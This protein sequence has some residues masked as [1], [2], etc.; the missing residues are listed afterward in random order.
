MRDVKN[1]IPFV[2][3]GASLLISASAVAQEKTGTKT[4]F[5]LQPGTAQIIL[6]RPDIS[7]GEQSTGGMFE[8]NADWTAQARKNIER[9]LAAVHSDLGNEIIHYEESL[10]AN[11][12]LVDQYSKLFGVIAG[13][14]LKYQFFE[15][16]R[17]PTKKR[18]ID[19]FDWGVGPGLANIRSLTGADY[20]LYVYTHDEY[21]SVGRKALQI[22]GMVAG[23]PIKSGVHI[24][25]AG[26]IDLKTGQLVW[27]NADGAMGGDVRTEEGAQKRAKQLLEGFPGRP[28]A[29]GKMADAS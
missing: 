8:P 24:G 3:V 18:E 22:G 5:T 14:V 23:F 7:V 19:D 10:G 27:L 21:G 29:D 17:L 20:L 2:F 15:G 25:Y 16:N 12:P 4:G 1:L 6:M 13:S 28:D 9:E 26:L 11:D